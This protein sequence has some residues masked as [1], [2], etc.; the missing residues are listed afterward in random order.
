MQIQ[1]WPKVR[2]A[3]LDGL[4]VWFHVLSDY[5][6]VRAATVGA[7]AAAARS[8]R[9]FSRIATSDPHPD[10][11]LLLCRFFVICQ[12]DRYIEKSGNMEPEKQFE[13]FRDIVNMYILPGSELEVNIE[14]A[15]RNKIL[16]V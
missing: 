12:L 14:T 3:W 6:A 7:A 4:G 1:D 2:V 16:K 11:P 13:H 5:G 10:P 8:R 15:M 9:Y